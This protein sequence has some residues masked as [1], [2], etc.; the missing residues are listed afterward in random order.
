MAG[1]ALVVEFGPE[2]CLKFDKMTELL[3]KLTE[4]NEVIIDCL[5][6]GGAGATP[7]RTLV[8]DVK[9]V[10]IASITLD[11]EVIPFPAPVP[12][13]DAD[14]VEDAVNAALATK[15]KTAITTVTALEENSARITVRTSATLQ[16]ITSEA[17][18]EFDFVDSAATKEAAAERV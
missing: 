6:G 8:A 18:D 16:K 10:S 1:E 5:S 4:Q 13:A 17:G 15:G 2:A 12:L 14:E 3:E 9:A 11:G 7:V